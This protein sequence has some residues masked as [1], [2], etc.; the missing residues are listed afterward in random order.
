MSPNNEKSL[1]NYHAKKSLRKHVNQMECG[2]L[3][4]SLRQKRQYI[5]KV[6]EVGI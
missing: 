6:N 3:M 4:E 1:K 5:E 2:I